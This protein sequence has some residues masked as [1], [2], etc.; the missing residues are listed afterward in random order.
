[1]VILMKKISGLFPTSDPIRRF[2]T[3]RKI[4][5]N[6][7]IPMSAL[8]RTN[9]RTI[10]KV[11]TIRLI[12]VRRENPKIRIAKND[13]YHRFRPNSVLVCRTAPSTI[14]DH[15]S[16]CVDRG[17]QHFVKQS[18]VPPSLNE[19]QEP[20]HPELATLVR[21]MKSRPA[22]YLRALLKSFGLSR[23]P[24]CV[25]EL[26]YVHHRKNIPEHRRWIG[27]QNPSSIQ[28]CVG[29]SSRAPTIRNL[30][31]S[32]VRPNSHHSIQ[33]SAMV[34]TN[35]DRT[36]SA[37]S[38]IRQTTDRRNSIHSHNRIHIRNPNPK[39]R[40]LVADN[41]RTTDSEFRCKNYMRCM[42]RLHHF[43]LN[44]AVNLP[45]FVISE[46]TYPR[47]EHP[48][49]H[50]ANSPKHPEQLPMAP[51]RE[52]WQQRQRREEKRETQ[53]FSFDDPFETT[54][55]SYD[56]YCNKLVY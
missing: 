30:H 28:I 36:T 44:H 43:Q 2:A 34:N 49:L 37:R 27:R 16:N 23:R 9:A 51:P 32:R 18:W 53:C 40:L 20:A 42:F 19:H 22:R 6:A 11:S 55:C 4:P 33:S 45:R 52:Q 39:T 50:W 14:L 25:P 8:N 35:Q 3:N 54:I 5:M 1:M 47:P 46:L 21:E 24:A 56:T 13:G 38:S 26:R 15:H 48:V 31:N 12:S 10:R 7:R 29:R 17:Q 41:A